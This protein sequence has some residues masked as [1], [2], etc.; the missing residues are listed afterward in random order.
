[1]PVS[2]DTAYIFNL[3]SNILPGK[4][5]QGVDFAFYFEYFIQLS[6]QYSLYYVTEILILINLWWPIQTVADSQSLRKKQSF[7]T[8]CLP[9]E[10]KEY[11]ISE[12]TTKIGDKLR[13]AGGL[14]RPPKKSEL[15]SFILDH[16]L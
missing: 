12:A 1:M 11:F 2:V 3:Q 14:Q 7:C 10:W 4:F 5:Q 6:Q 13:A 8:R 15:D 16:S 9:A